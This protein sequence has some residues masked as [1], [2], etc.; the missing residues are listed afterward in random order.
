M[1][2]IFASFLLAWLTFAWIEKPMRFSG[3]AQKRV[4]SLIILAFGIGLSGYSILAFAG[5]PSRKNLSDHFAGPMYVE[6]GKPCSTTFREG[7]G[8]DLCT[9]PIN[10]LPEI[11]VFGDSHAKR[12]YDALTT[13][14]KEHL[15]IMI[16]KTGG[17][18]ELNS[19]NID[20]YL[21]APHIKTII[22]TYE[23]LG[24][25][26]DVEQKISN[27]L[28]ANK[29]II[30]VTDNPRLPRLPQDCDPRRFGPPKFPEE[31]HMSRA[32]QVT[33]QNEDRK[34]FKNLQEK[35]PRQITVI[36]SLNF[37]CE[38]TQ[39]FYTENNVYLYDDEGHLSLTGSM[40]V[41]RE[42]L[43]VIH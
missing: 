10:G 27:W 1:L 22:F 35:Y 32:E 9:E 11:A 21:L 14:D 40:K 12:L 25:S 3:N 7:H 38:E 33:R 8:I 36:D 17:P 4:L 26:L 29:Q 20:T 34:K 18:T 15:Y 16:G 6:T 28:K 23:Q 30:L 43:Q 39:C 2:L 13:L 24:P 42:I 31:C 41:A 19:I 5:F 37:L